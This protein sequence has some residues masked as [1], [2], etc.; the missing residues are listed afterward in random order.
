MAKDGERWQRKR[1]KVSLTI[2]NLRLFLL[3]SLMWNFWRKRW[4]LRRMSRHRLSI[5]G[6]WPAGST[7]ASLQ[8]RVAAS[9][10]D[11]APYTLQIDCHCVEGARCMPVS[12]VNRFPA[13]I[14]GTNYGFEGRSWAKYYYSFAD[15]D[16]DWIFFWQQRSS[17]FLPRSRRRSDVT[18]TMVASEGTKQGI[19]TRVLKYEKHSVLISCQWKRNVDFSFL[20]RFSS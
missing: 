5:S 13:A 7:T 3:C 4:N 12:R 11:D 18:G 2:G 10:A 15:S 14:V 1:G 20:S 17:F 8:M 6:T 9:S 16:T 19:N